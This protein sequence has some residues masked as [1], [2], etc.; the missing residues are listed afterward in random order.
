MLVFDKGFWFGVIVLIPTI[1][2]SFAIS[3]FFKLN[4]VI[5]FAGIG[6]LTWVGLDI[7]VKRLLQKSEK[8]IHYIY[9]EWESRINATDFDANQK[10][11]LLDIDDHGFTLEQALGKKFIFHTEPNLEVSDLYFEG[12]LMRDTS[13]KII[14]RALK[15]L[16]L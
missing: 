12:I 10:S 3:Q 11:T 8:E 5:V 13:S 15:P 16:Q 1:G 14:I 7:Q 6:A 4:W 2:L 9:C